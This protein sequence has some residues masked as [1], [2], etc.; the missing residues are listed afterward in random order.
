M[1]VFAPRGAGYCSKSLCLIFHNAAKKPFAVPYKSFSMD[2]V[3][4]RNLL[5]NPIYS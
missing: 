5:K 2:W 3:V 1:T 4:N